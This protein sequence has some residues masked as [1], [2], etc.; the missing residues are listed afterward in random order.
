METNNTYK[1][2]KK[3]IINLF[4][5]EFK[6]IEIRGDV[7]ITHLLRGKKKDVEEDVNKFKR[8]SRDYQMAS[9]KV[10]IVWA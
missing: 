8:N 6:V 5:T 7:R 3:M 2:E 1:G 9:K 10:M 4:E